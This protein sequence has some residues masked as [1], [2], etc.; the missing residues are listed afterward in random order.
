MK[1]VLQRVQNA[2]VEVDG[3]IVGR[4]AQGLLVFLGVEKTDTPKDCQKLVEKLLKLR[5]FADEEGK[6]N[7][8]IQQI[9]GEFLVISQF[10]LLADTRKGTRPSFTN[11]AP[12]AMAEDL[13]QFFLQDLRNNYQGKV[14]EGVFGGDMKVSLLN[15]GPFTILLD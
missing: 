14:A 11:A 6:T 8:N 4:I 5:L 15:D 7:L 13:Y 9:S 10:T 1:T 12:P 2:S 3:E